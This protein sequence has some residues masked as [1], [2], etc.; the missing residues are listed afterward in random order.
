MYANLISPRPLKPHFFVVV[1]CHRRRWWQRAGGGYDNDDDGKFVTR[2]SSHWSCHRHRF[3]PRTHNFSVSQSFMRLQ[4]FICLYSCMQKNVG[5]FSNYV[6][7]FFCVCFSLVSLL[8]C[9][10]NF[11][12]HCSRFSIHFGIVP[13]IQATRWWFGDILHFISMHSIT[14]SHTHKTDKKT[15][16][17]IKLKTECNWKENYA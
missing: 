11:C 4:F 8:N 3:K 15:D 1:P 17:Q 2:V 9:R 7:S 6:L 12:L 13:Y 10:F 16:F 5:A 14:Q